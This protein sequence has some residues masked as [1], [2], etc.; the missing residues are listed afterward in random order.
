M[1]TLKDIIDYNL[2]ILFVGINPSPVSIEKG[3]YHQGKLGK[4][5]WQRLKK[6]EILTDSLKDYEDNY[7]LQH[8]FGITDIVK[9][10]TATSKELTREDYSKGRKILKKKILKY[11]P[12]ILCFIYKKAAEEF[13]GGKISD[14][15]KIGKIFD[16]FLVFILPSPYASLVQEK[17]IMNELKEL[18][19]G[20]FCN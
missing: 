9:K 11:K 17:G 5:F 8:K 6:Y 7:L 12:K 15:G 18:L 20:Q 14:F 13:I 10:P 1:K 16:K 3:H 19:N 2:K 4:R